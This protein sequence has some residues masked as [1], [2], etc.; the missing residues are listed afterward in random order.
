MF[1]EGKYG[2]QLLDKVSICEM[3]IRGDVYVIW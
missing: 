3:R 2:Y 1:M